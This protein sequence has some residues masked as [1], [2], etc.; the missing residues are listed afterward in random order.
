MTLII[1]IVALGAAVLVIVMLA[2]AFVLPPMDDELIDKAEGRTPSRRSLQRQ[3]TVRRSGP[4][5]A[6][7]D[8][9][10]RR[11]TGETR[12][13][14]TWKPAW[15]AGRGRVSHASMWG[16]KSAMLQ[17]LHSV[18]PMLHSVPPMLHSFGRGARAQVHCFRVLL[19]SDRRNVREFRREHPETG[20]VLL[21]FVACVV[22]AAL[23]VRLSSGLA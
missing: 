21:A 15:P 1:A 22:V 17:R 9:P 4:T 13:T 10:A 8:A 5:S 14:R 2:I 18:A 16:S 11:A 23:I 7:S 3:V 12:T 20:V 19:E 6:H